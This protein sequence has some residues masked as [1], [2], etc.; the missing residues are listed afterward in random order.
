MW[1]S[2]LAL[3]WASTSDGLPDLSIATENYGA[4]GVGDVQGDGVDDL[5][6]WNPNAWDFEL[7]PGGSLETVLDE[8]L[9]D[10]LNDCGWAYDRAGDV[11][12]DGFGDIAVGCG[13]SNGAESP[14]A[15]VYFGAASGFAAETE[16]LIAESGIGWDGTVAGLGDVDGDGIDD[17]AFASAQFRVNE[18]VA[19]VCSGATSAGFGSDCPSLSLVEGADN[20]V[21][22]GLHLLA[23]GDVDGDGFRD[24]AI[25]GGDQRTYVF[26][27]G[28]AGISSLADAVV[29]E[30]GGDVTAQDV[31][32]DGYSDFFEASSL[33]SDLVVYYGSPTGPSERGLVV[34]GAG[35]IAVAAV[36]SPN[37]DRYGDV[38]G[39]VEGWEGVWYHP[40]SAGGLE[41]EHGAVFFP[42]DPS[43]GPQ[44]AGDV[45]D[46]GLS[47]IVVHDETHIHV[48]FGAVV[49][50]DADGVV[51]NE[52]CD[53]A[54]PA[55]GE[56]LVLR[57]RDADGDGYGSTEARHV[58]EWAAGWSA[59]SDDCDDGE[60]GYGTH[61]DAYD[62]PCDGIDRDCDGVGGPDT[63]EDGDGLSYTEEEALGTDACL[64]DTDGDGLSDADDPEPTGSPD[65]GGDSGRE[66]TG[67]LDSAPPEVE[68]P[69][70]S[71]KDEGGCGCGAPAMPGAGFGVLWGV[72]LGV[73]RRA[74]VRPSTAAPE[75][76]PSSPT[77]SGAGTG[78]P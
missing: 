9:P 20:P 39:L 73:R 38:V 22:F 26:R 14:L 2:P 77:A 55:T 34:R 51:G 58:C 25:D 5:L 74:G 31:D 8:V 1:L 18:A 66:E 76:R 42:G 36:G 57:Y 59:S 32:G 46:D 64:S 27:G 63:D 41:P 4:I 15:T 54:D 21:G 49:D 13:Q 28:S 30:R 17:V 16:P 7:R 62:H 71:P 68:P 50:L 33:G 40:G 60:T 43:G 6:V 10:W 56:D 11:N 19:Y 70:V 65:S 35:P 24:V 29:G 48:Y 53:D 45:N 3:T 61:P 78:T 67:V 44:H 69:S 75:E 37:G 47:D 52:D 72:W 23:A 12:Q